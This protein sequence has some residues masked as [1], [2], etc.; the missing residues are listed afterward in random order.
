VPNLQRLVYDVAVAATEGSQTQAHSAGK[1]V[2][3][4]LHGSATVWGAY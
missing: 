1:A 4:P 2:K 3:I